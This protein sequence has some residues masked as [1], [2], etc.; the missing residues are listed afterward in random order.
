MELNIKKLPFG[1]KPEVIDLDKETL[2][3][4]GEDRIR[5]LVSDHYERL[6]ESPIKHLFP[7]KGIG[8]ELAKKHSADFFIQRLG[9]PDYFN[10]TRGKPMLATRHSHFKITPTG[11]VEWLK[12]Y[13]ELLP[14]LNLPE[15]LIKNYWEYLHDFSNWMV[16][17]PDE[18]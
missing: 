14:Q 2:K 17:T 18:E 5:K 10:K 6:T 7:P 12:I 1:N 15:H 9:G 8:L 4:L 13:A 11:R 3:S 16:N